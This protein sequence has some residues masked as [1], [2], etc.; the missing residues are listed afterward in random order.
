M[1]TLIAKK[2]GTPN[3][4]INGASEAEVLKGFKDKVKITLGWIVKI[5]KDA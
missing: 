5:Y 2:R 3:V 1:Y 4:Y